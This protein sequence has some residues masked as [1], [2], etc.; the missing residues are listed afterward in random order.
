[1]L[2]QVLDFADGEKTEKLQYWPSYLLELGIYSQCKSPTC[3]LCSNG[4][5]WFQATVYIFLCVQSTTVL[6]IFMYVCARIY[7]IILE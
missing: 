5:H 1:M 2:R 6:K 3:F 7:I 4:N